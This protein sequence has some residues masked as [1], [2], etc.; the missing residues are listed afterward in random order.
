MT[1][2]VSSC[3]ACA[4]RNRVPDAA[5]GTPHCA[6]CKAPL[7]WIVDARQ[8]ELDWLSSSPVPVLVDFWAPW[9]GPCRMV[10]PAVQAAAAALAGHLKVVKVNVDDL[11]DVAAR[12]GVQGIPTLL[13]LRDGAVLGRQVGAS[14]EPALRAWLRSQLAVPAA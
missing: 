5:A 11:P 6:R 2:K 8:G 9:C 1:V 12:Y 7:P 10:G 4:T 13:V 3:P 14:T